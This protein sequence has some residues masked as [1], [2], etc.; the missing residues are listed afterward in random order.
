MA[1]KNYKITFE[2]TDGT[3]KSVLFVAPQG[4]QGE[5]GLQGI[6]GPQGPA[7][8]D[9]SVTAESIKKALGYIPSEGTKMVVQN[10]EP[11]D[12]SVIWI[13]P[14][15]EDTDGAILYNCPQTLTEAQKAQARANIGASTVALGT[16]VFVTLADDGTIV[17]SPDEGDSLAD[18]ATIT[19]TLADNG[20]IVI[21]GT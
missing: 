18:G 3:E 14:N 16:K 20:T 10:E 15:D 4:P 21:G 12:T 5:Q 11:T 9:A 7:G 1:D 8:S 19:V 2:M 6:Q 17:I 13:D